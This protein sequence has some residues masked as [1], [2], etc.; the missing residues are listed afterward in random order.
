MLS[1]NLN[2]L[3]AIDDVIS[4][5][6]KILLPFQKLHLNLTHDQFMA[7]SKLPATALSGSTD[8]DVG[9]IFVV[10]EM[11]ESWDGQLPHLVSQLWTMSFSRCGPETDLGAWFE[12]PSLSSLPWSQLRSLTFSYVFTTHAILLICC[13]R[14]QCCKSFN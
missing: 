10:E 8:L 6:R 3:V 4:V 1:M 14:F 9:L 12:S 7:L 13:V 11:D 2:S 5:L